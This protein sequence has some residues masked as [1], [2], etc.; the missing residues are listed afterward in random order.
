[1]NHS[2][3][4][5]LRINLKSARKTVDDYR[6]IWDQNLERARIVLNIFKKKNYRQEHAKLKREQ[7]QKGKNIL[8]IFKRSGL[9]YFD[10]FSKVGFFAKENNLSD[11]IAALLDPHEKH[12]FGNMLIINILRII[13]HRDKRRIDE[14]MKIIKN[15]SLDYIKVQ[16]ERHEGTTI[17]DITI[18]SD[19]FLICIENK[20]RGG[21]ETFFNKKAQTVRQ[22]EKLKEMGGILCVPQER[23]LGILLT[24]EGK[25]P[26]SE[27]F[28]PLSVSELI[29]A[30]NK[31]LDESKGCSSKET[32]KAFLDFYSWS[33]S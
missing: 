25:S 23:L 17:P 21:T 30:V 15:E 11:A 31:T 16:R 28:I 27:G 4:D 9:S 5:H 13:R 33:Y 8:R 2:K 3:T 12:N 26:T 32:I 24:P 20:I 29:N 10:I 1:M 18:I 14:I 6:N 22:W 7:L 19:R